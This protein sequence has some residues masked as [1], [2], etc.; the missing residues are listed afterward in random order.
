VF[1]DKLVAK[2]PS[3]ASG[4]VTAIKFN[5]DDIAPVGHV[6][7]MIETDSASEQAAVP[8]HKA[9]KEQQKSQPTEQ[10]A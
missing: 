2:I 1:T 10:R 7:L 8:D 3:T 6:L 5:A 9:A 4:K